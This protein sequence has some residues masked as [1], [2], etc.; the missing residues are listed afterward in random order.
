MPDSCGHVQGKQKRLCS[1]SSHPAPLAAY[2]PQRRRQLTSQSPQWGPAWTPLAL[3]GGPTPSP[4]TPEAQNVSPHSGFTSS[5]SSRDTLNKP[6]DDSCHVAT[7]LQTGQSSGLL[8]VAQLVLHA[9]LA[10]FRTHPHSVHIPGIQLTHAQATSPGHHG[11][12]FQRC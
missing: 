11:L 2:T 12:A 3:R 5:S 6:K 8:C 7:L 9:F 4:T 10:H 1:T